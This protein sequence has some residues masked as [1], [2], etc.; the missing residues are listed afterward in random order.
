MWCVPELDDKYI[1]NMEDVLATYE[2][3][4]TANVF[5]AV[6]P[7]PDRHFTFPTPGRH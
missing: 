5:V 6:E 4:G 3:R 2:R 1:A 7:T